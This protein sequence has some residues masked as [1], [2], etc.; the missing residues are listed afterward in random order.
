MPAAGRSRVEAVAAFFR[1]SPTAT[2]GGIA[3][4]LALER[5]VE[6]RALVTAFYAALFLFMVNDLFAWPGYL[7]STPLAPRWPVFW[8]RFVDP[9]VGIAAILGLYLAGGLVAIT[10]IGGRLGRALVAFA[11]L[12]FLAFKF[13]FGSIHHGDHLGLLLALVLVF[14]PDGWSA[15]PVPARPKRVATLL[16]FS[17]CQAM[18]LL[19]YSMAGL[20]KAAGVIEQAVK[21][22]IHYLSPT[23]LAQQVA[24]KLLSSETTSPL[25]PWLVDWPWIAWAMMAGA[26]YLELFAMWVVFRP[27]LHRAWG[28]GLIAIHLV[29]VLTMGVGFAQNCLWL[30]LFLVVSPL[31]PERFEWR[32]AA[33]ELPLLGRWLPVRP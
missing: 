23:G 4:L 30:A 13:S 11:L 19:T 20:W 24:A 8:L 5:Y 21:G 16:V 3:S 1:P 29:S 6:A 26:I 15:W 17:G 14:L 27:S 7:D 2:P 31:R 28:L 12:E 10:A 9:G 33:R 22:E 25:G 32:R 18:I